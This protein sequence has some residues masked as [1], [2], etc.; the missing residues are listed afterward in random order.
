MRYIFL[1]SILFFF[2]IRSEAQRI[3]MPVAKFKTGQNPQYS[4]ASFD[5]SKWAVLKT[6]STWDNQGYS[7]YNGYGWYRFH[8]MLPTS[9]KTNSIWKDSLRIF[10]AK[11]DDACEVFLNG[12]KIG[13]SGSFPEDKNGYISSWD[14]PLEFHVATSS[15][16][17]KWDAENIISVKVYDGNGLGGLFGAIPYINMMD[18]IDGIHAEAGTVNGAGGKKM[19]TVTF[20]NHFSTAISGSYEIVCFDEATQ[21]VISKKTKAV[22]LVKNR[23]TII[24]TAYPE[25]KE[26]ISFTYTFTEKASGKSVTVKQILPYI[27]TP[28]PGDAPKINGAK[29][30][31]VRPNSP[32][33]FKIPATG[34]KPM[35]YRV[36]NLPEG[37]SVNEVNGVITGKLSKAGEYKMKLIVKNKTGTDE[38]AFKI[39]CGDVLAL[40]PPMGWNS[41]NCWGL[42]VTDERIKASANAMISKGLI[43]HGWTYINI[44][45]GWEA[46]QRNE[47][48][49]IVSNNKFPDMKKLGDWLHNN[50]LKFGIYSSPGTRTC[51]GYLGSYQHE[52]QDASTYAAWGVDYLKYDWCSYGEIHDAKDTSLVSYIK[53][54]AVM[55]TAL[56]KQNRDIVYSLCQYGMKDV[57]KWGETV[58]GNCWRTTG[59][60]TDTWESLYNIG[61]RQTVQYPYAKPGRWNDPDMMIVGQV[62]WGDHLHQSKLTPDEQ[63]THVSLWSLLNA[64]L[65]IGCDLSKLDDFTLSLLTNDEVIAV[66]QDL[67]GKQA[68]QIIKTDTYQ[69]WMKE[70]EDGTK[71][72]GIFNIS[73][74]SEVISFR[75]SDL[76]LSAHQKV[77]DL[78]RQKVLGD[79]NDQFSTRV[80]SHGVT[81]IKI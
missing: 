51:G 45:D 41:W 30:A 63:Y 17:L 25:K 72:I 70:M 73:G 47:Q 26:Q 53:P 28:K 37:L 3:E 58:N 38:R 56:Q 50:G 1:F 49:E 61:F 24:Y 59:D 5:D 21:T 55:Q 43:D 27:L 75:W 64:P 52:L 78:W 2:M 32:F 10:M 77:R 39:I 67:A 60:I 15:S 46:E 40:T 18:L 16:I 65:L 36:D 31:G 66:N 19:S 20:A 9:L 8:V 29:A 35:Q 57:W 13:K 79:F 6:N 22:T 14:E 76:G 34:K 48:G 7:D 4:A 62:G 23:P 42:S 33:L 69:V 12:V 44:D 11:A 74:K 54:Y 71:A 80:A 68:Q 81:L